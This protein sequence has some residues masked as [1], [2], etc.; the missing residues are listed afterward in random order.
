MVQTRA[1]KSSTIPRCS[2]TVGYGN[3]KRLAM[4][5]YLDSARMGRICSRSQAAVADFLRLHQEEGSSVLFDDF[6]RLGFDGSD[7]GLR[8]RYPGLRDWRGIHP[9][10]ATLLQIAGLTNRSDTLFASSSAQ[11]VRLAA[12]AMFVRCQ[13]A[14]T[15]DVAWPDY[16]NGF[17]DECGRSGRRVS[18]IPIQSA[19]LEENAPE[20]EVLQ[21]ITDFYDRQ[22]CDGVFIPAVTNL[23]IRLPVSEIIESVR[24]VRPPRFVVV[25]GAQD[26]C[27]VPRQLNALGCDFY[28]TGCHKWLQAYLPMRLGFCC[29]PDSQ[30][31]IRDTC[32]D[33]VERRQIDDPLLRFVGQ[34]ERDDFEPFTETANLLPLF[35]CAGAVRE[36]Q[37]LIPSLPAR[38]ECQLAN[39]EQL[40]ALSADTDWRTIL[41]DRAFRSG[42]V[43]MESRDPLVRKLSADRL[44]SSFRDWGIV[45]S[46]YEQ[47]VIRL[48][49]PTGP[50]THDEVRRLRNALV[51]LGRGLAT[52]GPGPS[53]VAGSS[54]NRH[55]DAIPH[56]KYVT[57]VVVSLPV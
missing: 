27:H 9:L 1:V 6:L 57:R 41:P 54:R 26:F 29:R 7:G 10:K 3:Q 36:Q 47:G 55:G 51:A 37:S 8:D 48:S 35:S 23:G 15:V 39:A 19:I 20:E 45:V 44:R 38:F 24:R 17:L 18:E 25:D 34:L 30:K 42:V 49:M 46:A 53:N 43:L 14:L 28:I 22:K 31:F 50:W 40:Q 16:R 13:N 56:L 32:E 52:P 12:R 33:M 11:L 2:D 21:R 4:D 5:M